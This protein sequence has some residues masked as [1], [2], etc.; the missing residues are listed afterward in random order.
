MSEVPLYHRPFFENVLE[1]K[2]V[3]PTVF[4]IPALMSEV[5][6]VFTP[7]EGMIKQDL[8]ESEGGL[9]AMG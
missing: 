1:I 8:E 2:N 3:P 5:P 4:R 7:T 6:P 9:H